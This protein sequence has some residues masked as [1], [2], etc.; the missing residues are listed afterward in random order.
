MQRIRTWLAPCRAAEPLGVRGE[1]AAAKYLRRRGMK[2]VARNYRARCGELD[3]V[4]IDA[5]TIVFVEV[6]TRR[7]ALTD[8]PAEA[9][10]RNQQRRISRTAM[11]FIKRHK[12]DDYPA[13]FDIVA[14]T[15]PESS[16]R[17]KIEHFA[18]AF[19]Y[20]EPVGSS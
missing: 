6:K 14:V 18:A 4:A 12:L 7:S 19:P 1:K 13:R 15:W 9:V 5:R 20:R 8:H 3:L 11:A 2:I 10:T 16:R 17:P